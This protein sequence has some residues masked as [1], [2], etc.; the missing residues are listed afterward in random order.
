MFG[1]ATRQDPVSGTSAV[2]VPRVIDGIRAAGLVVVIITVSLA[3]PRPGTGGARG[4]AIAV[5][6]GLSAAAWIVWMLSGAGPA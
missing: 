3:S 6:L 4:M 2:D 1:F 5:T